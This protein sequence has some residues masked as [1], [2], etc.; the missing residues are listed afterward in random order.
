MTERTYKVG[1][2]YSSTG[3]EFITTDFEQAVIHATAFAMHT[4]KTF[5]VRIN[6]EH[7]LSVSP[8]TIDWRRVNAEHMLAVK[9]LAHD[10][11]FNVDELAPNIQKEGTLA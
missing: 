3:T 8:S 2:I 9:A 10:L 7:L 1:E 11:V 5:T 6:N 4:G